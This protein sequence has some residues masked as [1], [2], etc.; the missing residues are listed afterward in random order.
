MPFCGGTEWDCTCSSVEEAE[1]H[2]HRLEMFESD[3]AGPCEWAGVSGEVATGAEEE[4][5]K[6]DGEA[7]AKKRLQYIQ[8]G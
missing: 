6:E 5:C 3:A 7:M 1:E 4:E 2:V 8:R